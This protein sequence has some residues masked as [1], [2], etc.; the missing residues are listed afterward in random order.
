MGVAPAETGVG[1]AGEGQC[2]APGAVA[3]AYNRTG[4]RAG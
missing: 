1:R 3:T 2:S 4:T